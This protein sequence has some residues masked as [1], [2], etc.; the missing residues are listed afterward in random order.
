MEKRYILWDLD[1]TLWRH[2]ENEA[3][4]ITENLGIKFS[5]EFEKDFF[6]MA[7][8][9][10]DFFE[11]KILTKKEVV[12]IIERTIPSLFFYNISGKKFLDIWN[13]TDTAILEEFAKEVLE[14]TMENGKKNIILT[15][16]LLDR[17]LNLLKKF[18]I[19]KYI[20]RV[21]SSENYYTKRNPRAVSRIIK[22]GEESSY[23]IIG[24][25]LAN[26]IQFAKNANISSIWYNPNK[27]ENTT[28]I[29]PD[30]EINDLREVLGIL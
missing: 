10:N 12:K 26:D 21:Y 3:K 7:S 14:A 29:I 11:K 25:S 6:Y 17:Q 15:D 8:I 22:K 13:A 18:G 1:G 9:I 23:I 27:K 20:E 5:K 2:K 19:L 30:Y 28:K 4:L 24:D 16:W